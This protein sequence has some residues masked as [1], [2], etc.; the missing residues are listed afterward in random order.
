[1]ASADEDV[2]RAFVVYKLIEYAKMFYEKYE[3]I[4]KSM[5]LTG[6][7]NIS[8]NNAVCHICEETLIRE[9]I[10]RIL[11]FTTMLNNTLLL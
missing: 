11:I 7:D 6:E 8:Y 9:T 1:M 2:A 4:N 5:M 10:M 3:K